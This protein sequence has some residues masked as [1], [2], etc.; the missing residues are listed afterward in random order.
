MTETVGS[1][2]LLQ[3][4][5]RSS[6]TTINPAV[7]LALGVPTGSNVRWLSP[8]AGDS[9]REYRDGQVLEKL[10]RIDLRG[11]L[12]E[13]WPARGPVWDGLA[14][15]ETGQCLLVEAK[16]HVPEL[17][18]PGCKASEPSL[19]WIRD[20]LEEVRAAIAPRSTAKWTGTFYQYA[21]RLAFL[22]FLRKHGVD[23]HLAHVFFVNAVDVSGPTD[24]A[25][26]R[27]AVHLLQAALGLERHRLKP[28]VHEI[29]LDVDAIPVVGAV[30]V[31]ADA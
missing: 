14:V 22:Y 17:A 13:F 3:T 16:A 1:Q 18:S 12:A 15:F 2:R 28:F 26:W 8:V 11:A 31:S 21:N 20:A 10:G 24:P 25:E 27:G 9:Y 19:Q 29:I 7:R 6:E 23:A 5:V 4:A 30:G